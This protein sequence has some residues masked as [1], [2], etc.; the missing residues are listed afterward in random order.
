[1][2]ARIE[3]AG[4]SHEFELYQ[5]IVD[6][7]H[8]CSPEIVVLAGDVATRAAVIDTDGR[9]RGERIKVEPTRVQIAN[10]HIV[11]VVNFTTRSVS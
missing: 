5:A 7:G 9:H 3:H 10:G 6:L 4:R 11:V 1:M 8:M 2:K